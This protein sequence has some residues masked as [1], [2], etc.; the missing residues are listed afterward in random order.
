MGRATHAGRLNPLRP[1]G[2][3]CGERV[4]QIGASQDHV[5]R[6]ASGE[7]SPIPKTHFAKSALFPRERPITLAHPENI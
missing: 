6:A 3:A 7:K 4:S 5:P 2:R 1:G